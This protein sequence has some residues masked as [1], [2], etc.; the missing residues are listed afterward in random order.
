MRI[1][2][3]RIYTRFLHDQKMEP[4]IRQD[5]SMCIRLAMVRCFNLLAA[6][7]PN[8]KLFISNLRS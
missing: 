1:N 3:Q 2:G 8:F 5:H 7:I 4:R 6:T